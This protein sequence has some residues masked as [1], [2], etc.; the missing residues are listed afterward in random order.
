MKDLIN[1]TFQMTIFMRIY[2]ALHGTRENTPLSNG[3]NV[4]DNEALE[5]PLYTPSNGELKSTPSYGTK[6]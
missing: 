6:N 1:I 4:E 3:I 2:N 5:E